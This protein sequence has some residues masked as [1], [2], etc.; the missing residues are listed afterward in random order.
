MYKSNSNHNITEMGETQKPFH[1]YMII[2]LYKYLPL[3]SGI[4]LSY[5]EV[6]IIN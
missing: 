5:K 1:R 2:P 3:Y 6:R 4:L